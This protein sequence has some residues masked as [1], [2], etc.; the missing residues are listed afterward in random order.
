MIKHPHRE[1]GIKCFQ[2]RELFNAQRQQMRALIV[3]QQFTHRLKL[4]EEKLCRID[5]DR[6]M[7]ARA[8]HPPQ[9]IAAAAADIKD[10]PAG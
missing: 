10:R 3:T 5:A 7:C 9:V 8:N 4:A 6:Q 2:R 1:D